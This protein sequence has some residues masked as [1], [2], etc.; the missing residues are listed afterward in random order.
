MTKTRDWK[1][2]RE[3]WVG[4]LEKQTGDGV[5]DW[6]RR[7]G[8]QRLRDERSLRAW[9]SGQGVT[10]YAQSLLVMER[11]GYPPLSSPPPTN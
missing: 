5:T 2:N 9:L 4:V 6:N 1:R 8:K 7:I 3:M 11:F 10:G